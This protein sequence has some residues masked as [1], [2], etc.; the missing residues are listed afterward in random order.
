M[1][2]TG[3]RILDR[4]LD[5]V[6]GKGLFVKEL[7]EALRAGRVD[8]CVHSYKDMPAESDPDLPVVAVGPRE[9]PRDVLLLP[10]GTSV[11]DTTKPIGSS[12]LRRRLQLA[13]LYPDWRTEPVRGNVQTR[14]RKMN[15]GQFGGLVLA[16][17]GLKRLGLWHRAARVFEPEE[18]LPAACQGIIAVQGRAGEEYEYLAAFDNPDA[19]D[20]SLAERAFIR[21]LNGGCSSPTAA[22]AVVAGDVIRLRGMYVGPEGEPLRGDV[23][24]KRSDAGELGRRLAMRLKGGC[25]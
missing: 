6:G 3:D 11:P 15:D 12:S 1:K 24:G 8:V 20:A 10:D 17:A 19:R 14:L 4:A 18:M 25:A 21:E 16:A 2:T 22:Y 23:S 9:D 13:A 7:D 5:T